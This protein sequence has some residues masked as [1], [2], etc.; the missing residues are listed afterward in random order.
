MQS[1]LDKYPGIDI[2]DGGTAP[3]LFSLL[4]EKV[5]KLV[6]VDALRAGGNTGAIY[7]LEINGSNLA[8]ETQTSAHGLGVLDSLQ[9]MVR[10]GIRPPQVII[11]GVEPFDISQGFNLSPQMEML[12]PE[13][14]LAVEKEIL[15]VY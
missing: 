3:D 1:Q 12:V 2:I 7:H 5:D 9:M 4:D 15:K 11:I 8:D 13:L 14:I 10:L 6:I